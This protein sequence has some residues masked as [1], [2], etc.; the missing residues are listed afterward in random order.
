LLTYPDSEV[1]VIDNGVVNGT[2]VYGPDGQVAALNVWRLETLL[3]GQDY[4][5]LLI[6]PD[7]TWINGGVFNHPIKQSICPL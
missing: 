2:L 7:Q 4:R 1:V 6:E 3:T 5:L